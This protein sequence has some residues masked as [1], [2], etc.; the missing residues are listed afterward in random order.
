MEKSRGISK[1]SSR[2]PPVFISS[3]KSHIIRYDFT[4]TNYK[5]FDESQVRLDLIDKIFEWRKD[6]LPDDFLELLQDEIKKNLDEIY[7]LDY[8]PSIYFFMVSL[9]PSNVII[10]TFITEMKN[11]VI[12]SSGKKEL[13]DLYKHYLKIIKKSVITLINLYN[14]HLISLSEFFERTSQTP[15]TS[16]FLYRG[17]SYN[18][19]KE[20]L[21]DVDNQI[22][23]NSDRIIIKSVL[24]TSLSKEVAYG[25]LARSHKMIV[26][27]I[28]VPHYKFDKFK[29]SFSKENRTKQSFIINSETLNN[30]EYEYEF[31]LNFGLI[32]KYM[33]KKNDRTNENIE[34][35]E[36]DFVEYDTSEELL[37]EFDMNIDR[38]IEDL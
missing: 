15:P 14:S 9:N 28:N 24:S 38:F 3:K 10:P 6:N 30:R 11:L 23:T 1:K 18:R 37:N 27:K 36:F 34:I 19:Y 4:L 22:G 31:L 13:I 21:E 26:W 29:Y 32:L 7:I 17:F 16:I 20:L 2:K 33:S 12:D 5:F 25:F 35:Y 8:K